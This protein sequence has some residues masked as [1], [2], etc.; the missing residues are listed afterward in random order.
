MG[1]IDGLVGLFTDIIEFLQTSPLVANLMNV[2]TY[3]V[4]LFFGVS[5]ISSLSKENKLSKVV[6]VEQSKE[7]VSLTNEL[8][9]VKKEMLTGNIELA[10]GLTAVQTEVATM[11]KVL[12]VAFT[13]SNLK[14]DAKDKINDLT[15]EV[16]KIGDKVKGVVENFDVKETVANAKE[17][18]EKNKET[19]TNV[20]ETVKDVISTGA[21]YLD[22]IKQKLT[23]K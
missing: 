20:I 6:T 22:A 19:A 12:N 18:L 7:I 10:K 23:G 3:T 21:S 1:F 9:L 13:N 5:K 16:T 4:G 17:N 11:N 14:A 8:N 15:G 2:V